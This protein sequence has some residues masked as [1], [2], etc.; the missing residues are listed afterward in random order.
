MTDLTYQSFRDVKSDP[1]SSVVKGGESGWRS[2][3]KA[4]SWRVIGTLDTFLLSFLIIKYLGP[5]F[6]FA[7]G[8]SNLDIAQ[9]ASLIAFVEIATKIII[10]TLHE[11]GWNRILWGITSKNGKRHE[12]HR[13]SAAKMSTWRVLASL[14][15][16]LLA[17]LFTGNIATAI[18]IGGLEVITKLFLYYLHERAWLKVRFGQSKGHEAN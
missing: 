18:S 16:T 1:S 15:T 5:I 12:T 9:T 7:H 13:R 8:G 10:F 17:W 11:R 14:D 4:L 3:I 2:F 6:G